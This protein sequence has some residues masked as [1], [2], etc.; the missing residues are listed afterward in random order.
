MCNFRFQRSN[1]L[2][3]VT[4][5]S[6]NFFV[7]N[8]LLHVTKCLS[9]FLFV[10]FCPCEL[11]SVTFCRATTASYEVFF[12]KFHWVSAH[13]CIFIYEII[14]SPRETHS[15]LHLLDGWCGCTR[16]GLKRIW[17]VENIGTRRESNPGS[18]AFAA[19]ALP[20]SYEDRGC[21]GLLLRIHSLII[22][23]RI[24]FIFF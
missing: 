21:G 23:C 18:S 6:S 16:Q 24:F 1:F 8:F 14:L 15:N 2:W 20:L 10:P 4:K 3:H 17:S 13:M 5:W 19:A 22:W 12:S 9:N 7:C 11:L